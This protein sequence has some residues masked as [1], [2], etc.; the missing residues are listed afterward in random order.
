MFNI[1]QLHFRSV[2]KLVPKVISMFFSIFYC[3]VN[4]F[5]NVNP[6]LKDCVSNSIFYCIGNR[7]SNVNPILKDCVSNS[8]FY[9]IGNR[10]LDVNPILKYCASNS[11]WSLHI[12][13]IKHQS[14]QYKYKDNMRK[15]SM[16]LL[17][18]MSLTGTGV[19][20]S[21][22]H[23]PVLGSFLSTLYPVIG[24]PPSSRGGSHLI[25]INLRSLSATSGLPGLSGRSVVGN[26]YVFTL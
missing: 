22:V 14:R 5:S 24:A 13:C 7:F 15:Y 21:L 11:Q 9:C 18:T 8:I 23:L 17:L 6:I 2:L 12:H 3:I 1:D 20:L 19:L 16:L 10:F 25:L 26:K 4:R